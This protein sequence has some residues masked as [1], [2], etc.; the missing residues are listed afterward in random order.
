MRRGAGVALACAIAAAQL[1]GG[2][3]S[4]AEY[5][6]EPFEARAQDGTA[7][8]GHV[9][10]PEGVK[11][12]LATVLAF[13]PYYEG[14]GY[15]GAS[16]D[17]WL[18]SD[19]SGAPALL[20]A[21]FAIAAVSM[22]G[23][24]KSDGCMR[25]GDQVDRKDGYAVVQ[26]LAKQPWSNGKVGMIGH[27]Y[28]AW[29]QFLTAVEKPPALKA[30][31]PT[32][33]VTDLWTLLAR[34]GAPLAAGLGTGF[35]VAF[36]ALT[37]H[38]PPYGVAHQSCPETYQA[39][40]D[41]A[42]LTVNGDKTPYYQARDLRDL[43]KNSSVPIMTSVGIVSG[44]NDGHIAQVDGMWSR[45]RPDRTRFVL[46]QWSHETPSPYKAD[47]D[48]QVVGWFDQYL[49]GGPKTV[50]G[51]VVEYQDDD[52]TWHKSD[53]WPPPATPRTF[54]FSG[55]QTFLSG[56]LDPGLRGNGDEGPRTYVSQCGP[57]QA[58][59][60]TEPLTSDA[61]LAGYAR[62]HL[63]IT[64]TLPGGNLAV[65]LWRTAGDGSCPDDTATY[66]GRAQM[67]LRHWKAA[68]RSEDLPV[69][70]PAKITLDSHPFAAA[71][72][73]GERIVVAIGG[74]SSELEPDRLK[75]AITVAGGSVRL[76]FVTS[77]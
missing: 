63:D 27:S 16:T 40:A 61:L 9:Y 52:F 55:P 43:L 7:L 49:R 22:R 36:T 50:P 4:A 20:D 46:G 60:A 66:F 48:K 74:G 1:T 37:G 45:L 31:V 39:Y 44:F 29:S 54:R 6:L 2:V 64:S 28:P 13:A 35:P 69:N 14:A 3:A 75:P 57:H 17:T 76:P 30:I 51:G 42:E 72:R 25:F 41:N 62:I 68:G 11:R 67:D 58:L 12:P 34:R 8:R 5:D 56:D 77:P 24:G 19:V 65:F 15:Q 10:L 53:R 32:S 26:T 18:E 73:K 70:T 47:W 33:G 59:F 21:G 71:M 38:L 23:T